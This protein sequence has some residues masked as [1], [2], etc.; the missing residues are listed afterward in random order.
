MDPAKRTWILKL[1]MDVAD[2]VFFVVYWIS[3]D[4]SNLN[5]S[6]IFVP[7][8]IN[9]SL[10]LDLSVSFQKIVSFFGSVDLGY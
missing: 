9:F 4:P 8:K 10:A 7:H 1:N 5:F 6:L 3:I 2:G